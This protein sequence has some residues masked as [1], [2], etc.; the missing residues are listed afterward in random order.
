MISPLLVLKLLQSPQQ[1]SKVPNQY[2]LELYTKLFPLSK[3]IT[4]ISM[5]SLS[6]PQYQQPSCD[7]LIQF[8]N[9]LQWLMQ[10]VLSLNQQIYDQFMAYSAQFTLR[11]KSICPFKGIIQ[12]SALANQISFS[13]QKSLCILV[14]SH[15]HTLTDLFWVLFRTV[16][17]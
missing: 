11:I 17:E 13:F 15:P 9:I 10:C 8:N 2:V 4:Q 1:L 14:H 3:A 6:D 7:L 5:G 12:L 16:L